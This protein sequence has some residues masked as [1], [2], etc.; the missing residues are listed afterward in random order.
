LAL[1]LFLEVFREFLLILSFFNSFL[2]S[3]VEHRPVPRRFWNE[4]PYEERYA[5]LSLEILIG[6]GRCGLLVTVI[7]RPILLDFHFINPHLIPNS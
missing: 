2:Q 6:Y 1:K 4:I 5:I 3:L 7:A